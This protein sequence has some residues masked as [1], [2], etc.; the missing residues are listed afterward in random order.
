MAENNLFGFGKKKRPAQ[1]PPTISRDGESST[2]PR[3]GRGR[4]AA[5]GNRGQAP[6]RNVQDRP[7][8]PVNHARADVARARGRARTAYGNHYG[9]LNP[10]DEVQAAYAARRRRSSRMRLGRV[11][12]AVLLA[13]IIL[14]VVFTLVSSCS[15]GGAFAH[16]QALDPTVT[17]TGSVKVGQAHNRSLVG[18]TY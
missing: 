4:H 11:A 9:T 8:N 5:V 7:T 13:A 18:V 17:L 2:S 12:L 1:V 3:V 6:R 16:A 10:R 14:W 15:P